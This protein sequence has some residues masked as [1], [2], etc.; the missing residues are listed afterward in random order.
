MHRRPAL[1]LPASALL[2]LLLLALPQ[3]AAAHTE[4]QLTGQGT[5]Q[6]PAWAPDGSTVHFD[7]ARN[8]NLQ[9]WTIAPTGTGIATQVTLASEDERDASFSPDGSQVV[10]ATDDGATFDLYVIPAAGGS[11]VLLHSDA[12]MPDVF[13]AWSPDG[14]QIAFAKGTDI[15]VIPAA[16]GTPVQVTTDPAKDT[17]PTWSPDG[18]QIAFQSDRSG[19]DDIWVIPAT[20]GSAV[21]LTTDPGTDG[22]PDWSPGG[23]EIAFQSDRTGDN[24]IWAMPATGG[25]PVQLTTDPG[26]D[27]QPDWSADGTAIAFAR[28]GGIW[29]S[30]LDA[31][32][33]LSKSVDLPMPMEG[34]IVTFSVVVG[35]NGPGAAGN[36]TV[37]DPLAAG[38]A[39]Q[40]SSA[41]QGTYTP[42]SGVW[43]VGDVDP[44]STQT[45]TL[46]ALIVTGTAGQS[47]TNT[48]VITASDAADPDTTNNSASVTLTVTSEVPAFETQLTGASG[49]QRPAWSPDGTLLAFDSNRVG[50]RNL[51]TVPSGGGAVLQL[52]FSSGADRYPEWSP[53]GDRVAFGANPGGG[54]A[55][56]WIKPLAGPA[57]EL[58]ADPLNVD[59][60]PAW[61]PDSLQIAYRKGR[62]IYLISSSGGTP[63]QLTTDPALDSH[64]SWSPDGT[65]IVFQS[66]RSGNDDLWIIPA[67]GGTPVQL[68]T[69][70]GVD[71][72]PDWSPDG[73][74]IAFQSDRADSTGAFDIWIIP[75]AGGPAEQI[76]SGPESDNAPD[77]SPLGNEIAFARDGSL[78]KVLLPMVDVALTKT[79]DVAAP[80]EG[81]NVTYTVTASNAGPN[82]ATAVSV[83]DLLPAGLQF[84]SAG[85]TNGAY[86]D[87]S[88]NWTM[89]VLG[90]GTTDTLTVTATIAPGTAGQLI[91]N[92]ATLAGVV[93]EDTDPL[94]DSAAVDLT[95]TAVDLAVAKTVDQAMPNE[96][97]TVVYTV[98][99][100]NA[101][102]DVA[103][104]VELTDL[105]P[106]G[107]TYVSSTV[108]QG[109]YD[110]STG[111][112]NVGSLAV[113]SADTLTV[114]ATVDA[115][116]ANA[117]ITNTATRTASDQAD[118]NAANDTA[119]APITVMAVDLA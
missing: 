115:G 26:D 114:T 89:A 91:T 57:V 27:V 14:T 78:W 20:G 28:D 93:E 22:S 110:D 104:G 73:T 1:L 74:E 106:A 24:E 51:F 40:S 11:P 99:V 81:G 96:G 17:H 53:G 70:P 7:S 71:G 118:T 3:S 80:D 52:T 77:W 100:G 112:W 31:E 16:G 12:T 30:D 38:L 68:T 43:A 49:D 88:G 13:P 60:F 94:N 79:V 48:S 113:G 37:T 44:L 42:G 2:L 92:T 36:V 102:P 41:T 10:Y 46:T 59:G 84:V 32:L 61:S 75:A 4:T 8:G 107:V 25:T 18:T 87:G 65:Q 39:L 111:V 72:G 82:D 6:R 54:A 86:D 117:T 67:A 119:A 15:Y 97:G 64:P 9:I 108:T 103:T 116:T 50:G 35:N 5:D 33:A 63:V 101:G 45:L 62:D 56:L 76:T 21:Q 55:N 19:N 29:I 90:A 47:I 98:T 109:A 66:D 69:D 95:V 83:A 85:T 34:Q 105:L 58:D 23:T